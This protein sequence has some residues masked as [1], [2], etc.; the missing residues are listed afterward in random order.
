VA[1]RAVERDELA[2]DH[3]EELLVAPVHVVRDA[4]AVALAR[5][6]HQTLNAVAVGLHDHAFLAHLHG[7]ESTPSRRVYLRCR[8]TGVRSGPSTGVGGRLPTGTSADHLRAL[9]Q[10]G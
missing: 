4:R 2:V 5:Q 3:R 9:V 1:P 6:R 10:S 8:G 7:P